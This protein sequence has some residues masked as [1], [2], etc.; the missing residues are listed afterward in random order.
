MYDQNIIN[1]TKSS[2]QEPREV[3]TRRTFYNKL[4]GNILP[5]LREKKYRARSNQHACSVAY[6]TLQQEGYGQAFSMNIAPAC[7]CKFVR[8]VRLGRICS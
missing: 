1:M 3:S 6:L 4:W 7:M 5:E 8:S 2:N